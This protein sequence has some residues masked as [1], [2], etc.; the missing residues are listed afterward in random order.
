MHCQRR[1]RGLV[2]SGVVASSC[3]CLHIIV[4]AQH[5]QS[6]WIRLVQGVCHVCQ[7][8]RIKGHSHRAAR[9]L[10]QACRRGVAFGNQQHRSPR[11]IAAPVPQ[12]GLAPA[13]Q[14]KLIR[15]A[16]WLVGCDALHVPQLARCITHRHQQPAVSTE[17]HTIGLHTLA[18]QVGALTRVAGTVPRLHRIKRSVS[19][20]G[21]LPGLFCLLACCPLTCQAGGCCGVGFTG[22]LVGL[23][24]RK[25]VFF[26]EVQQGANAHAAACLDTAPGVGYVL[27]IEAVTGCAPGGKQ[28]AACI[29]W[30]LGFDRHAHACPF[31]TGQVCR[32]VLQCG[33]DQLGGDVVVCHESSNKP[34]CR[35]SLTSKSY[36]PTRLTLP[37]GLARCR[38]CVVMV[39]PSFLSSW[40][41][42]RGSGDWHCVCNCSHVAG[43]SVN[44]ARMRSFCRPMPLYVG[45][46]SLNVSL[47]T[48][49]RP[50]IDDRIQRGF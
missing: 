17:A 12:P 1:R 26:G 37:S 25:A 44:R 38:C 39:C 27:C 34:A 30:K 14:E 36:N 2:A 47:S 15:P 20:C 19:M 43:P 11:R 3:K 50:R 35:S 24:H 28:V 22:C 42:A 31:V 10:V 32:D 23:R 9:C 5:Q 49:H 41:R 46:A 48:L 13:L 40:M 6:G 8:A 21:L 29:V 7:V 18:G 4:T 45:F 16:G 33:P